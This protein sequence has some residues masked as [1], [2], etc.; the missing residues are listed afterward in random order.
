MYTHAHLRWVEALTVLGDAPRAWAELLRVVPVGLPDRSTGA[1]PRQATCYYSSADALF[2]DRY[3]AQEHADALFDGA[4][5]F[6]GGWRVYSSGPGLVLRLLTERVLGVR[7][8]AAGV[9]VDPVLPPALDGLVARIPTPGTGFAEVTYHV[10]TAGC[11]VR[12]VA[13][14]GAE[15]TGSPLRA[16]YRDPGWVLAPDAV[17]PGS[18]VEVWLG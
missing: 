12:R 18:R 11:G 17:G 15:A 4:T 9:E 7:F 5:P 8:R 3:E 1:R 10:G 14:D 13:V 2:T 6:E 16:R